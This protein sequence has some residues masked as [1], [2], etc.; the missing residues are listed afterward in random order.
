MSFVPDIR[1]L[2]GQGALTNLM[3]NHYASLFNAKSVVNSRLPT[4]KSG[5]K[6]RKKVP[7]L[8]ENLV[9]MKKVESAKAYTDHGKPETLDMAKQLSD[10]KMRKTKSKQDPHPKTMQNMQRRIDSYNLVTSI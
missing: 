6:K 3:T 4:A 5:A 9:A 7:D 10:Y 2:G 8:F 1:N